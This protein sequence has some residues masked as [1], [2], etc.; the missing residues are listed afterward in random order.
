MNSR[1]DTSHISN[2]L[3]RSVQNMRLCENNEAEPE[4]CWVNDSVLLQFSVLF[5]PENR[6][7][8]GSQWTDTEIKLSRRCLL[9]LQLVSFVTKRSLQIIKPVLILK[10]Q[11]I[12]NIQT[13][14]RGFDVYPHDSDEPSD[15][16]EEWIH[17]LPSAPR[18]HCPVKQIHC[19]Y[20]VIMCRNTLL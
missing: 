7:I 8:R 16:D 20:S 2:N 6:Y 10:A 17:K 19:K 12:L 4:R 11:L 1:K 5:L 14:S 3:T 15:L 9:Y 18:H 13:Q